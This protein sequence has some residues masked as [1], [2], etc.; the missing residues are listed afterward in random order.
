MRCM[1]TTLVLPLA[2]LGTGLLQAQEL[3]RPGR[4]AED[5]ENRSAWEE[6]SGDR[7]VRIDGDE[8]DDGRRAGRM[9][10]EDR[11]RG[12]Q[13]REDTRS[14]RR[15]AEGRRPGPRWAGGPE[16]FRRGPSARMLLARF[17]R[18]GDRELDL[19]ELSR[20][21]ERMP[22]GGAAFAGRGGPRPDDPRDRREFAG[23]VD[24]AR[25]GFGER[26]FDRPRGPRPEGRPERRPGRIGQRGG[27]DR[28]E[29]PGP[30]VRPDR[31]D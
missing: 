30:A 19:R 20:L 6:F 21:V 27:N 18:D 2:L 3:D 5:R 16:G 10:R 11:R 29:R 7:N 13:A 17:D 15:A 22:R 26:E 14:E 12:P 8:R 1:S 24:R 23:R 31:D 28:G 9:R 25:D 4:G